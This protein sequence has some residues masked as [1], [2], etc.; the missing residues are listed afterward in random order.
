MNKPRAGSL[1][2]ITIALIALLGPFLSPYSPYEI[3]LAVKNLPPSFTHW[4]GTDE[5]GRDLFTRT[6]YGARISLSIGFAAALIDLGL[7]VFYGGIAAYAGGKVEEVMMRIADVLYAFPYMLSVMLIMVFLDSGILSLLAAMTC[8]GWITMARVVRGAAMQIRQQEF[9]LAAVGLG[10][11]HFR[12]IVKHILPN[13]LGPIIVTA[14]LTV[15]S[16]IFTEAFL[17]FLGLGIQAPYASWGTMANEGLPALTFYPWRLFF[18]AFFI[19]LT[20]LSLNL[21]GDNVTRD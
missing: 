13:I 14:T 21:I 10:A 18:P 9:I 8:I 1:L 12:I 19:S 7:G 4:F 2:F 6:C 16:A 5:L 11:S 17:S 3:H 20:M 15:P